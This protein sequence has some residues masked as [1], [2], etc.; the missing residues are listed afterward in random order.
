MKILSYLIASIL[1]FSSAFAQE[2]EYFPKKLADNPK[3]RSA[4][5]WLNFAMELYAQ[6]QF[7]E[8]IHYFNQSI[9]IKADDKMAYY[10]RASCKEDMKDYQAALVDYQICIHL[11][12]RFLD[13][14][15]SRGLLFYKLKNYT[16]AERDFTQLLKLPRK[17]TQTVYY[18]N[19]SYG[20][21]RVTG[22]IFTLQS[23]NAEIYNYRG[24][25]R[26]KEQ[27]LDGA[28]HDFDS[29]IL[30]SPSNPNYYINRGL[31]QMRQANKQEAIKDYEKALS[32]Y[33]E[34]PLALYNL[35]IIKNQSDNQEDKMISFEDKFPPFYIKRANQAFNQKLFAKAIAD[36]DTAIILG[37]EQASTFY[38][39]GLAK[40][41]T[42]NWQGAL[43]DY[44]KS[45]ALQEDFVKAYIQRGNLYFKQ[46]K[47][48]KAL[49]DYTKSILLDDT[50][51]NTF[52]NRGLTYKY[53]NNKMLACQDLH[54][55]QKMG[56]RQA[57][58]VIEV[59]CK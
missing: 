33:P 34:H 24:L 20:N 59:I 29:A 13:A 8:A 50:N 43:K 42:E 30:L 9:Q 17:E 51:A 55:A 16:E 18:Q 22:G 5:E 45:I 54:K 44:T 1:A 52:Y 40:E 10:Y 3:N 7:T 41:K 14:L 19:V 25:A 6:E 37:N 23:H 53:L 27:K 35:K 57:G 38:N 39:R 2:N 36:Y 32:I 49:Q 11:D 26:M 47:Y 58:K 12:P 4:E 15:F 48:E 56:M 31:L 46:K 21:E 28:L